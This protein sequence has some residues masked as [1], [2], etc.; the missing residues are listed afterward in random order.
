MFG[1]AKGTMLNRRK[2]VAAAIA[3]MAVAAVCSGPKSVATASGT[4]RPQGGTITVGLLTDVTGAGAS[5]FDTSLQGVDAGAA[6]AAGQGYKIKFDIG[7]TQSSPMSALTAAERMVQLD[8]VSAVIAMSA[9]TYG[10]ARFLSSHSVPVVGAGVDADEWDTSRNMFS[11]LGAP[12]PELV[13][14]LFGRLMRMEGGR[15][16]GVVG[17]SVPGAAEAAK[18][19]A[20]STQVAGLK[21]GYLNV[22][23]PLGSTN[24][25]PAVLAM[26]SAGVDSFFSVTAPSTAFAFITAFKQQGVGLK[27]VLLGDGYGGDL[28]HG[29]PGA[30]QAAQSV[31]FALNFEP[32]EM[33]TAATDQFV[34]S[35]R[36]VGVTGDPTVA[37]Y[38]GY[39]SV[40]LLVQALQAAGTNP[41]RTSLMSALS[42]THHFTAGGLFGAQ[43]LDVDNR[44][45]VGP[46]YLHCAFITRFVGSTFRLVPHADPFC[47]SIIPGRRVG[48][49]S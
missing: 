32:V 33:H 1:A 29:G 15:D 10:A 24:V 6:W 9:V 46:G 22:H 43:G 17:L 23:F 26:K 2:M 7:D 20:V 37:E 34:R 31:Y 30:A 45:G 48:P 14:D 36:G 42:T 25:T 21:V 19:A 35:L 5:G 28:L 41:T 27:F 13:S 44:T 47:G 11:V 18:G 40:R 3:V 49:S 16:L 39:V 12:H 38:E 4:G 8:H